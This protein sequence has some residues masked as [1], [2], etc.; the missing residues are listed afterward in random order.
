MLCCSLVTDVK[1]AQNPAID[2]SAPITPSCE[3]PIP[4]PVMDS[5]IPHFAAPSDVAQEAAAGFK[6]NT[7]AG[8]QGKLRFR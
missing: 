3:V 2:P 8:R 6:T 4:A 1:M 5:A 7:V